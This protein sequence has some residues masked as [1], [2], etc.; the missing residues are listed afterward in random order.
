MVGAGSIGREFALQ[1]FGPHTGTIVASIVDCND[2]AA[3]ALA[4]D[5]GS[6]LAGAQLSANGY[7]AQPSE[8]RG[9]PV[10]HA[11][12]L[13]DEVLSSCDAVYI[14]TTPA[15]HRDLVLQALAADK[16]VLLEKPLAATAADA[17]AIVAAAEAAAVRGVHVSMNIGMRYNE[18]LR[19]MRRRAVEDATIGPLS[20]AR[21]GLHFAS[22]PREWQQVAWCAGRADGGPLR[23]VGTHFFFAIHELF[24]HGCVRRVRASVTFADDGDGGT[25]AEAS[26]EGTIELNNGL[27]VELS[28]TTDGSVSMRRDLY[29]LEVVG[30]KGSL[31]LDAFTTLR[32]K[33]PRKKALVSNADYGR[34]ECVL[35]LAA[36]AAQREPSGPRPVSV[37]EGRNAQRVLDALLSSKGQWLDVEYA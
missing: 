25:L 17:D 7:G 9:Q 1:H 3:K 31:L 37:R 16:H 14:G 33:V 21:L 32:A 23:E 6:V 12:A 36:A 19:V 15:A 28:L 24:G 20:S 2:D 26:A 30:A 29:H 11:I 4:M 5:T 8:T 10:P 35:A 18:A 27:S 34:T 13:T 22:W